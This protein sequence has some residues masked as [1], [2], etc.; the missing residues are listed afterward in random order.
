MD[1]SSGSETSFEFAKT[2]E[3]YYHYWRESL[4]RIAHQLTPS[5]DGDTHWLHAGITL[6][7]ISQ[8]MSYLLCPIISFY[9]SFV[10]GVYGITAK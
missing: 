8:L 2:L 1:I 9:L 6:G 5:L 3:D 4:T 10:S 7:L